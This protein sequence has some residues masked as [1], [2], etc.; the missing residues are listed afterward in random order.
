MTAWRV[1]REVWRIV[2]ARDLG[3]VSAGVAFY[4]MLAIFPGVAAVIALWGFVSDPEVIQT[5]LALMEGL[6]PEQVMLL[7]EG[8]VEKLIAAAES[9][10]GWATILSTGVAILSARSGVAALMRGLNAIHGAEQK[11][12][13]RHFA[14]AV[15]VTVALV[16]IALV[17][18]ATVVVLPVILAILPLGP[19]TSVAVTFVRWLAAVLV[20][21]YGLG[22]VY[23]YGP[24]KEEGTS[25]WVTPGALLA[26]GIWAAASFGFS[27][28]VANFANYNEVY[29][30]LGA[31]VAL[32]MWLYI[33]AYVVLLGA[34]VNRVLEGKHRAAP[35]PAPPSERPPADAAA[36]APDAGA[37]A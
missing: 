16:A 8:Q 10:L 13:L 3:L 29:G 33:S 30:T 23:R 37:G 20:M 35:K 25:R 26:L 7:L 1:T 4:A 5:Q 22:L 17:A 19:L 28:Y 12:G 21:I 36:P 14:R 11:S 6:V 31:A 34:V 24:A 32:L 15:V 27:F 18:L 9:T 2:S